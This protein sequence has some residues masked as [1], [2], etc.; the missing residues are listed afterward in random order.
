MNFKPE[1]VIVGLVAVFMLVGASEAAT[2]FANGNNI[3]T[4]GGNVTTNYLTVGS[5]PA[6]CSANYAMTFYNG[7]TAICTL[8]NGSGN[9]ANIN[10]STATQ[11]AYYTDT[12]AIGGGSDLC[13]NN[14]AGYLGVGTCTPGAALDVNGNVQIGG[15][16]IA[17]GSGVHDFDNGDISAGDINITGYLNFDS[18]QDDNC[19]DFTQ[20]GN[21]V[22][23]NATATWIESPGGVKVI[24]SD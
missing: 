5:A 6:Q 24:A 2:F 7:S 22:C 10:T 18:P 1:L 13:W 12:D 11:L 4:E 21:K 14:S 8:F 20:Y 15:N 17:Y 19:I 23:G 16:F 3:D 9:A